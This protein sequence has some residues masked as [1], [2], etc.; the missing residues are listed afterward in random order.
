[1]NPS[2]VRWALGDSDASAWAALGVTPTGRFCPACGAADH[3]RPVVE[4]AD[5]VV[6]VELAG[7]PS[8]RDLDP[9]WLWVAKEALLKATGEGILARPPETF[10]LDDAL[11]ASALVVTPL[12]LAGGVAGG[13]APPAFVAALC[14]TPSGDSAYA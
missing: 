12:D 13:G 10:R 6:P 3:G 1:M 14:S 4:L 11:T 9:R 5:V 8:E 2:G 7:H